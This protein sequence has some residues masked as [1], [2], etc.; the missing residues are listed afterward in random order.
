[1]ENGNSNSVQTR[2]RTR[3]LLK[4]TP[5]AHGWML[6]PNREIE[7]GWKQHNV[8]LVWCLGL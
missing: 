6:G 3:L 8:T 4:I 1:M 5:P 2:L 7:E